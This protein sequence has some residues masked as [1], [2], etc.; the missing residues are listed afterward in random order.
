MIKR[1]IAD[2]I[3]VI[4]LFLA[5]WYMTVGLGVI[6]IILFL[7]FWE[8]VAVGLAID[9]LYAGKIPIFTLSGL[10]L[11]ILLNNIR[12]RIRYVSKTQN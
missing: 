10:I 9:L 11:V 7:N 3:L 6:F 8:A 12:K 4:S 1:I 5:P 2:G